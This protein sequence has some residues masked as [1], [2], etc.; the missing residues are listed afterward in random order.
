MRADSA[1]VIVE[2]SETNNDAATQTTFSF[3][4]DL[5]VPAGP[6]NGLTITST[7]S[8]GIYDAGTTDTIDIDLEI[9]NIGNG[10]LPT[11]SEFD[12]RLFI[13]PDRST[14][15]SAIV[16]F[17]VEDPITLAADLE[18][19]PSPNSKITVPFS[20]DVPFMP[21][22]S[23]FVGVELDINDDVDE[24]PELLNDNNVVVQVDGETNNA[25]FSDGLITI[26]GLTIAE[27]VDRDVAPVLTF[28]T[29]GDGDWFGQA[30]FSNDGVDAAQSPTLAA[31]EWASF[32]TSFATPVAI[33]FDWSANTSSQDNRLEF[34]VV[35]GTTGGNNNSIS[36]NTNGW[37]ENVTR[38]IPDGALAEWVYNQGAE[39][40]GDTVYVD[41][42]QFTEITEPD[43]VIDNILLPSDA[44]GS[45]VLQRDRLDLTLNSRNQGTSTAAGEEYVISVYLSKDPIFD[46]PDGDPLTPDDI[47]IRQQVVDQGIGGGNSAVN[48][49]SINLDSAIEPGLYY[50]IGYIDDYTD[51]SGGLLPG[52]TVGAGEIAEFTGL[53]GADPFPGEDNNTFVTDAAIVEIVALPDIDV[54][55]LSV[56]PNFF[57]INDPATNYT[58]PND[59]PFNFTL[60]NLGLGSINESFQI[61]AL[62]SRDQ[63]LNPDEDYTFLEYNFEGGLGAVGSGANVRTISPD[64]ADFRQNI[65]SAGFIGE[66]LFFGVLADSGDVITE[67]FENNNSFYQFNNNLILS[68]FTLQDALDVSDSTVSELNITFNNDQQAPYDSTNIPWVGQSTTSFDGSDAVTSVKVGNNETSKFTVNLEPVVP[69]RVSFWWKVSSEDDPES[70]QRDVLAF[71][72]DG[73][74]GSP[75]I[76]GTE[77]EEWRRVEVVLDA[78]PHSLTWAYIKDAQGS[79]GADRG[80]VDQLTITEL[81]NLQVS[82]VSA[83]DSLSYQAGDSIDT[84]SVD[85]VNTG[86]AIEP[87]AAFETQIRLLPDADWT[88]TGAITLLTITDDTGIGEGE[89]RTYS[90]VTIGNFTSSPGTLGPLTIPNVDF[91]LEFYHF[92]AYV[93]WLEAD[94]TGGQISESNETEADNTEFTEEASIQIGRPDLIGNSSSIAFFDTL[95]GFGDPVDIDLTLSNTGDGVLAAGSSFDYQIFIARTDEESDLSASSTVLLGSGSVIVPASVAAGDPLPTINFS[96]PLPFG[97]ANGSYFIAVAID[98]NNDVREQGPA[99]DGTGTDGEANNVFFSS[100]AILDVAG[101]SLF[102]ALEDGTSPIAFEDGDASAP[103]PGVPFIKQNPDSTA[104]WFGRDNSGNTGVGDNFTFADGDGAQSPELQKGEFAEFSLTVPTSSLVRFDWRVFSASDQNV[105]SVLVNDVEVASISGDVSMAEIDPAVL[106]P[107]GGV[108]TWRYAK[109]ATTSGDF[110]Y[111]DDLRIDDNNDPDL[112]L[113]AL[114]YTPGEYILDVGGIA[115]APDQL[116]GTEYLDI[117]VE[118]TNQGESITTTNFTTADIEVRL[119]TDRIYGND[120]DIVLGTV[121]QV[122]GDLLS[123]NLIRFIGPIQ[124]GDS[125]PENSYYLMARIDSNDEVTEFSELNNIMIS[126]NRDVIVTRLPALRLYNPNPSLINE[127]SDGVTNFMDP[128]EAGTVAF[129]VDEELL[130]YPEAP[131]RLRFSVQNIGLGRIEAEESWTIK[132]DLVGALRGDLSDAQSPDPD[133]DAFFDAFNLSINLGDFSVQ[134]LMEGRSE[135]MPEGQILDFD[136]ELAIPSGSRFSA[137]LPEDR[138]ISEYLWTIEVDLDASDEIAQSSI[139]RESPARIIPSGLPWRII[140]PFEGLTSDVSLINTDNDEGAFGISVQ[141]ATVSETDWE[142]LYGAVADESGTPA[143]VANFLAYAF[144]RNPADNDTASGQFPGTYGITEVQGDEFL[145]ISFDF[146]TRA[147]DLVYT[148]EADNDVNFLSPDVLLTITPPFVDS[149]GSASLTGDGGLIEEANVLTVLDQ[150]YSARITVRDNTDVLASPTRFIRVVV[151]SVETTEVP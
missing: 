27:A 150:G 144:N 79:A 104:L 33:S 86:E 111:I 112:V 70:G 129:D 59:L 100:S 6:P 145:S 136:V 90:N 101:T 88:E 51:A 97:L 91:D 93:D 128:R 123:G 38:V 39:G 132:V 142:L 131:M 95:Y 106:V 119:S 126:E 60:E 1:N 135:G 11:G 55:G 14:T 58:E 133:A 124:L 40:Q 151:D 83:D 32:S 19:A 74:E 127:A 82:A 94:P 67:L 71:L 109:G 148:I 47:L 81:P 12:V 113:T 54:A 65:V 125:I 45:Y 78:G 26:S 56:K 5:V 21:A 30:A 140:E 110:A 137:L 121:S 53:V 103:T 138:T 98:T 130:Y 75:A 17:V 77:E 63:E 48:G 34:R 80:W 73:A 107:D 147:T 35:N 117:T 31:G 72:V 36:G 9:E 49:F 149:A 13:S 134:Q 69:V 102:E 99:P 10:T 84:W 92:G 116:L 28:E 29:D 118:A 96:A 43:L 22:G 4:P 15:N 3:L 25:A 44:P 89:T 143:E 105:L 20:F 122:E 42:L 24:Q 57:F 37:I 16:E 52:K 23:Y 18:A 66:R 120:N 114:N 8:G 46:R 2:N 41:D 61:D 85:V 87:G 139:V 68:E 108:V 115:G 64:K 62:F 50:V 76:F 141:P 7:P 146:V